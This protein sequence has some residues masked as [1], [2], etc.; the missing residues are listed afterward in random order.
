MW[1]LRAQDDIQNYKSAYGYLMEE[2]FKFLIKKVFDGAKITFDD[3]TGVDAIIEQDDK[4]L[5]IEFTTEYYRL[6]SLYDDSIQGFV[7]DAYRVLFNTGAEDERRRGKDDRGKLLKLN[8]YVEKL[9]QDGKQ[10]VPILI[11]EKLYR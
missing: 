11:T 5:V 4:V 7:D 9:K 6:S 10:I 3:A 1:R 2:Y 8:D